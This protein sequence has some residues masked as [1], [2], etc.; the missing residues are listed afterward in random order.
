M[1]GEYIYIYT[2]ICFMIHKN[3]MYVFYTNSI[4]TNCIQCCSSECFSLT[5]WKS[6]L[7]L[8]SKTCKYDRIDVRFN[9]T[10]FFVHFLSIISL[11]SY[12]ISEAMPLSCCSY[13]FYFPFDF[14]TWVEQRISV[15][16]YNHALSVVPMPSLIR[17]VVW[18]PLENLFPFTKDFM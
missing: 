16:H 12:L 4:I 18:I 15:P 11:F 17:F 10:L 6:K 13:C 8:A 14:H 9:Y 7:L 5:G 2:H 3:I 1:V